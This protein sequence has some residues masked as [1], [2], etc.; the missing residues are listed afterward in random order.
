MKDVK[1]VKSKALEYF[2]ENGNFYKCTLCK[3]DDIKKCSTRPS[4]N[5]NEHLT[6]VHGI[7]IGKGKDQIKCCY[8]SKE[9]CL[10]NFY[11]HKRFYFYKFYMFN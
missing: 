6:K 11:K 7:K 8:C 9:I 1:Q 5:L 4:K 10:N 3:K 2:E